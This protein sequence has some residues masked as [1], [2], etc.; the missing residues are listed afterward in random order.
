[1]RA[2]RAIDSTHLRDSLPKALITHLLRKLMMKMSRP[3]RLQL[4]C[5]SVRVAS[6]EMLGQQNYI[7]PMSKKNVYNKAL[8]EGDKIVPFAGKD[9]K[10]ESKKI[11][12]KGAG[13]SCCGGLKLK[14]KAGA[15]C[16]RKLYENMK[17]KSTPAHSENLAGNPRR[18][19]EG[20]E[21]KSPFDCKTEEDAKRFVG[22]L[23]VHERGD[24]LLALTLLII[25]QRCGRQV[26]AG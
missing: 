8:L 23:N 6:N 24:W 25:R 21:I 2:S 1:M 18:L 20:V 19:N 13:K 16:P 3:I 4:V 11:V 5:M 10:A 22:N 26:K 15:C 12:Y 9:Y 17:S 7:L 14:R